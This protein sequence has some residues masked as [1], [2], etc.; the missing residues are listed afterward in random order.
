M[1]DAETFEKETAA[2]EESRCPSKETDYSW[3]PH[4]IKV[5]KTWLL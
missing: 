1:I 5:R 2:T 3:A 4:D